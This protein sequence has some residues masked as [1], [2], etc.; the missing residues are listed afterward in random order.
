MQLN[1]TPAPF[2]RCDTVEEVNH[3]IVVTS[4]EMREGTKFTLPLL[5]AREITYAL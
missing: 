2:P 3:L 1:V 5:F 4:R